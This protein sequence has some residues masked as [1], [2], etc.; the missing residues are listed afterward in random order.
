ML[1]PGIELRGKRVLVVGL[2]RTGL[3]TALFCA[4]RGAHVTATDE[5]AATQ[6]GQAP[7]KLRDAGCALELGGNRAE[8]FLQQ[9]LIVPSPGVSSNHAGLQAARAAGIPVWSEM[10][11]AW[12]FLRGRMAAITGSNGKTTT[13]ALVAHILLNSGGAAANV[14]LAGNIG[15][16]LIA[17]V[18]ESTDASTAVVEASSFQL[19]LIDQL[20]PD[21]G[22]LLNLTPDHL[23]RHVTFEA[24]ARAKARMFE[25]QVETDAAVLNADDL[26]VA[27]YAPSRPQVFWFSR[28]R[29]VAA[30]AYLRGEQI[31]FCRD[32]KHSP[33]LSRANINL[34]GEHNLENV[35]AAVSVAFLMGVP[36]AAIA[37]GVRTFPEW[38]IVWN[39]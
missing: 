12:R 13:T 11:L 36:P 33:L 25:N 6:L 14:I 4:G 34:R 26:A 5:R 39:S 9:D 24:Y 35:M 23:D 18:D 10:E 17:R 7:E 16:P 20:R 21:V 15:T 30:G 38:S 27:Q 19:E 37:S 3:A 32:G 1:R 31:F 29:E 2:A 22:V 8:T 28:K